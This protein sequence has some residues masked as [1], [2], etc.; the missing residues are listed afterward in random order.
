Q[1]GDWALFMPGEAH[2]PSLDKCGGKIKK[3]IFKIKYGK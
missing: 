3:A 1:Q 2:A